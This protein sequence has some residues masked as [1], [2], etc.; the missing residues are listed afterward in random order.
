MSTGLG[1]RHQHQSVLRSHRSTHCVH[2]RVALPSRLPDPDR[3]AVPTRPG[4][5]R[6]A[7]TLPCVP[8]L[9]LPPASTGLLRQAQRWSP[10]IPTRYMAPR[11]APQ[12]SNRSRWPPSPQ[13]S[14]SVLR[15]TRPAPTTPESSSRT[16]PP[17]RGAHPPHPA[18]EHTPSPCHGA[19][20]RTHSDPPPPS[21]HTPNPSVPRACRAGWEA[22]HEETEIRA[23]STQRSAR[24]PTRQANNG[25]RAP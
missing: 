3:L 15:A 12:A 22:R 23:R 25:L 1:L 7:P 14:P 8:R 11:G 18:P 9:R 20:P 2:P 5:V 24:A 16:R 4:V 10:F 19:H 17:P 6:A 13:A 21:S